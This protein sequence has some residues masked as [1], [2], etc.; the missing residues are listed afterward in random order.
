MIEAEGLTKRY[1]ATQALAGVDLSV[2]AGSILGVLGPNGAGK[3]TVVRI[4]D[5]PGPSR[6]RAGPGGRPR[7]GAPRPRPCAARSA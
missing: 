3:T 7:R 6:R 4:L 2:A 5:H 1:G